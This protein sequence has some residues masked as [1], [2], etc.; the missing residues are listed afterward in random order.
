MRLKFIP[1]ES[2]R[3]PTGDWEVPSQ[4]AKGVRA[5]IILCPNLLPSRSGRLGFFFS[6]AWHTASTETVL[7]ACVCVCVAA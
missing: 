2:E 5:P 4:N 6:C 1:R 3:E 7:S